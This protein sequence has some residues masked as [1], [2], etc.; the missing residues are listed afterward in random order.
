MVEEL[1]FSES[2]IYKGHIETVIR[3]FS[4]D[5]GLEDLKWHWDE[6]DRTI[7]PVGETDWMFQH[8]NQ[9]P[10]QILSKIDIPK[11]AWHRLIKGTA[12]LQL[13]VEKHRDI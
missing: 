12:D 7:H 2:V 13:I 9:L 5:A 3:T 6:E 10:I 8:D 1:P 4:S 11:G